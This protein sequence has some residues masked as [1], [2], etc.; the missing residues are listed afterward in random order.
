M[1]RYSTNVT[2]RQGLE[3]SLRSCT[4]PANVYYWEYF[5]IRFHGINLPAERENPPEIHTV[6]LG[7]KMRRITILIAT[8]LIPV[9][10]TVVVLTE[11]LTAQGEVSSSVPQADTPGFLGIASR[12]PGD[13]GIE[14]DPAVV[15]SDNFERI[16]V[17]DLEGRWTQVDNKD[18]YVLRMVEDSTAPTPGKRCLQ[19]TAT[20]GHDM[21]GHLWKMLDEG[22]ERL[23]ARFYVKFAPDAPYVHH[24]VELGGRTDTINKYPIGGAGIRPDGAIGFQ[25]IF[26]LIGAS[27]DNINPPGAWSFYS[28]WCEM[29]SWQTSEGLPDGRPNHYYGNVFGPVEPLQAKR[30][31]WQCVEIMVKLNDPGLRNG[32]Q[33]FWIDGKLVERYAPGTITGTWHTSV[34]WRSGKYNTN[35]APFEGFR[36]RTSDQ[37]KINTF[38]LKYYLQQIFENDWN[39]HNPEIPYNDNIARVSF[40]NIVLSTEYIG[41][42]AQAVEKPGCDYDGDGQS[43]VLDVFRLIRMCLADV[44]D[45]SADYNGDGYCNVGDA[46]SLLLDIVWKKR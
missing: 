41:P 38:W 15:F 24:F 46:L 29:R 18:F 28:Y 27:S 10:I 9:L 30:D 19:M 3:S 12:Y 44:P 42:V 20:K 36:W 17:A 31:E 8:L 14:Q 7:T 33:A 26:D 4:W 32:E 13:V 6:E 43:G 37:L 40:D 2:N 11:K 25:T 45:P 39:P 34:F 21:G 22:Y 23:Y 16:T 1:S 5:I 35:P